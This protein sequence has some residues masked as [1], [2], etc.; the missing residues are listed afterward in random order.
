M[1]RYLVQKQRSETVGA[2]GGLDGMNEVVLGGGRRERQAKRA[3]WT[4][5]PIKTNFCILS[6]H[7]GFTLKSY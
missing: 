1:L 3:G 2:P 7:P 6:F 5:G 4:K